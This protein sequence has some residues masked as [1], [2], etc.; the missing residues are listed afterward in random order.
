MN[1]VKLATGASEAE[2]ESRLSALRFPEKMCAFFFR[3]ERK[4]PRRKIRSE[5][6]SM[7]REM[8]PGVRIAY[9]DEGIAALL[10]LQEEISTPGAAAE[11][12]RP[13][14]EK[15][16]LSIGLSD[17]FTDPASFRVFFLQARRALELLGKGPD[18]GTVSLYESVCFE[19]LLSA[20]TDRTAL[21]RFRHPALDILQKYDEENGTDYSKTLQV[22][23]DCGRNIKLAAEA[24]FIHRNTMIYRLARI[25]SPT[26]ADLEAADARFRLEASFRI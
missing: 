17:P 15:E 19:D 24:L 12:L 14:A 6:S 4:K 3:S 16:R 26:Q 11:K 22:F 9:Y 18:A 1:C 10:P 23:L 21:L 20:V 2:V 13:L 7:L 5:V 8:F 25:Q